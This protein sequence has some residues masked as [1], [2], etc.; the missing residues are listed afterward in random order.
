MSQP[1][2]AHVLHLDYFA[3]GLATCGAADNPLYVVAR[4]DAAATTCHKCRAWLNEHA[5]PRQR[6]AVKKAG[7]LIRFPGAP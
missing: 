2:A 3:L 6:S 5:T 4:Q 7:K 1:R